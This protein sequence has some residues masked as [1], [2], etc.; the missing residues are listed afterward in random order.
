VRPVIRG[1]AAVPGPMS[2]ASSRRGPRRRKPSKLLNWQ[3]YTYLFIYGQVDHRCF[4]WRN[5]GMH[6]RR[7]AEWLARGPTTRGNMMIR[8]CE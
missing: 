1:P 3:D 5:G 7:W 4:R 6:R 8:F 2:R